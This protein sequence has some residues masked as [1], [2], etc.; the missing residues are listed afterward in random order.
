MSGCLRSEAPLTRVGRRTEGS[1]EG[2]TDNPS[3][4]NS[5]LPGKGSPGSRTSLSSSLRGYAQ[6]H[7]LEP[8]PPT[9]PLCPGSSAC[10]AVST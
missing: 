2:E 4:G 7:R 8:G 3:D 10:S 5:P 1:R 9:A 6:R